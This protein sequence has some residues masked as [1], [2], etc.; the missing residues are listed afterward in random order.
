MNA[1][2]AEAGGDAI[3]QDECVEGCEEDLANNPEINAG[4]YICFDNHLTDGQCDLDSF[5]GC[6]EAAG[7]GD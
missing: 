3:P 2:V 1:C 7:L 4:V 6:A 5:F